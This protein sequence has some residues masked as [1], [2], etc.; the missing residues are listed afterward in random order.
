[1][2]RTDKVFYCL[3]AFIPAA[4]L[5]AYLSLSAILIFA[6]AA[7]AIIPLAKIIGEATEE[8]TTYT[9]S[10]V[11]GFLNA[12]FGN[13]PELIIAAFALNAGLIDV[14]KASITGSILSN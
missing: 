6:C 13:A 1:M 14:V 10:A 3:L 2:S 11:G 5:A 8:L 12:T 7:L 4:V 9:G